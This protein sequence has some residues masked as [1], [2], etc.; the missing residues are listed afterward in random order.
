MSAIIMFVLMQVVIIV[1]TVRND[2]LEKENFTLEHELKECAIILGE[3][4]RQKKE[5]IK[6]VSSKK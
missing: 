2:E 3:C 6:Y 5:E 1:E 4:E